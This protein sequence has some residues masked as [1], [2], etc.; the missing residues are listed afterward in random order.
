[1]GER[2][3]AD[4]E[5]RVGG[6]EHEKMIKQRRNRIN[7]TTG[8]RRREEVLKRPVYTG[9]NKLFLEQNYGKSY[10]VGLLS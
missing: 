8:Y 6:E 10:K 5:R 7:Y 2:T 3:K 9:S 1:M 4:T